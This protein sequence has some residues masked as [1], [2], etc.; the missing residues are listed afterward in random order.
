[1]K[2]GGKLRRNRDVA[3]GRGEGGGFRS[4]K[5]K[6]RSRRQEMKERAAKGRMVL[7]MVVNA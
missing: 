7:V 6:S 3:G 1:M 2:G 4:A 5:K